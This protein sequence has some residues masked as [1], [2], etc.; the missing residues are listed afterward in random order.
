MTANNFAACLEFTLG[1]EGGWSDNPADPGGQTNQGITLRTYRLFR[2]GATADDLRAIP[3]A[4]VE[5]IY[6]RQFWSIMGCDNLPSGVDLEVFDAGVNIG[7][8][9]A[10]GYLQL[11]A[12][13]TQDRIDGP[14]TEAAVAN[15][16]ATDVITRLNG[17]LVAHYRA[18]PT[19]GTFGQGWLARSER[20]VKAAIALVDVAPSATD[21][22]AAA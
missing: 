20:R 10:V 9:R 6:H 22:G 12:G 15:M 11:I 2:H 5:L 21:G 19:F 17:L 16:P 14:L 13:V 3:A 4:V 8:A 1:E 7:A 18:L